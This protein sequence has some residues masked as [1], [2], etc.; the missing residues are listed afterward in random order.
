MSLVTRTFS[1]PAREVDL[2]PRVQPADGSRPGWRL[3]EQAVCGLI[4]AV[5]GWRGIFHYQTS[6]GTLLGL[7]MVPV[8]FGRIR[9]FSG[10]IA[11]LVSGLLALVGGTV[12]TGLAGRA[13]RS[14]TLDQFLADSG[15]VLVLL[16]G[17]GVMLWGR[18]IMSRRAVAIFFGLGVAFR[19]LQSGLSSENVWKFALA[20][21][22]TV[23]LLAITDQLRRPWWTLLAL[24]VLGTISATHDS[25]SLFGTFALAAVLT[26][27]QLRPTRM[28]RSASWLW[29]VVIGLGVAAAIYNLATSLL[30]D[31]YFGTEA[32]QRSRQQIQEAGSLILGGR[33]EIAATRS[34]MIHDFSGFGFGVGPNVTDVAA[35]KTGMLA[36]NYDPENNYVNTYMFGGHVELHSTVGDLWA[37]AGVL[38]LVFMLVI[39]ILAARNLA[40]SLHRREVSGLVVFLCCYTGWNLF[41]SPQ[42]SAIPTLTLTL[43]L[44]M[45]ALPATGG[46]G[47]RSHQ[48]PDSGDRSVDG[49]PQRAR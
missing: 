20:I 13:G 16:V 39:A 21:P 36:I 28:G 44:G 23:V 6:Y 11:F 32:Q 48:Q 14:F 18:T 7:A 2:D 4:L 33:P 1:P 5:L 30:V 43:G 35:A 40:D 41:F 8:W 46:L 42:F 37:R 47:R 45:I 25:R 26:V 31:G 27:W 10:G 34:L 15:L 38:G 22:V 12:L 19:L 3:L 24:L 17:V 9:R 49:R 29:T